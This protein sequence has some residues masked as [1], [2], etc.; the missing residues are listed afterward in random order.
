MS[1]NIKT[2]PGIYF[3]KFNYIFLILG[4]FLIGLGYILMIGGGSD[5]P[6]VFSP[7]L[8][9]K[10]RITYAPVT[11]L[12]GFAVIIYAIMRRPKIAKSE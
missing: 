9:D 8:F 3:D 1:N 5:D 10:Q 7:A 2:G 11:C 4:I 6:N 12:I